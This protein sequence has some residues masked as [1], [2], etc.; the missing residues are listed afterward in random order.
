M[1]KNIRILLIPV[2]ACLIGINVYGQTGPQKSVYKNIITAKAIIAIKSKSLALVQRDNEE[3]IR[4]TGVRE[5]ID[6]HEL[7]NAIERVLTS[8]HIQNKIQNEW[9]E[10]VFDISNIIWRMAHGHAL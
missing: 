6:V 5:V 8:Q 4:Q 1:N 9:H 7:P 3:W 10:G 2:L